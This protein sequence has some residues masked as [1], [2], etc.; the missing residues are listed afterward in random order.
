MGLILL[1]SSVCVG[2][3]AKSTIDKRGM[4]SRVFKLDNERK[5]P[6]SKSGTGRYM[7]A[8]PDYN[9]AQRALALEMC[10]PLKIGNLKAYRECYAREL[11]AQKDR[12][13]EKLE[14]GRAK[15]FNPKRLLGLD[16]N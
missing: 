1:F 4:D 2:D 16:P 12:S 5:P 7:G 14:Y 15:G 11:Q 3:E 9:T 6:P 10:A 13:R 8:D